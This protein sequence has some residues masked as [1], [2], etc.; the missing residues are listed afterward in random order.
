MS[1]KIIVT[2]AVT[3]SADTV[4]RNPA[5]PVTPEQIARS[6]IEAANAGAAVVHV[7]VRDPK[8]GKASMESALYAETA[9]RIRGSNIDV[10]LN[11]TTGPGARL[12]PGIDDPL[13]PQDGTWY[14]SPHQRVAHILALRPEICSLDVAT[15]N[16][17]GVRSDSMFLNSPGHL[18]V[19]AE[20][21][22]DAGVKPEL[23]VFEPG[24]ILLAREMI[25]HGLI[26]EPPFFQL[27]LGVEWGTPATPQAMEFMSR[28]L[29]P[30]AQWAAFGIA[31]Q[32]FPM[33]AQSVLLGGHVRVG[34]EDNL[35]LDRGMLAPSN[36]ALV[37][38]ATKLVELLGESVA[39]PDEARAMM[40]LAPR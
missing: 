19:M 37:E 12:K 29:P 14:V 34:L 2:C 9:E 25:E 35:Y 33:A 26:E 5:V 3:G 23:E 10:V 39:S 7:H 8:T 31:R 21:I 1:R 38:K 15:M 6:A 22:R 20:A 28:L 13:T 27:C 4:A 11:L 36:A 18:R 30:G 40:G 24:H 32:S 16:S 17:G